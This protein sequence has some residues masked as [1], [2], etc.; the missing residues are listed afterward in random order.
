MKTKLLSITLL[1]IFITSDLFAQKQDRVIYK[2]DRIEKIKDFV[3][4]LNSSE[5]CQIYDSLPEY[6]KTYVEYQRLLEADPG[7][8]TV[9]HEKAEE[10]FR[11]VS[12]YK[13]FPNYTYLNSY[14]QLVLPLANVSNNTSLSFAFDQRYLT[15]AEASENEKGEKTI[16]LTSVANTYKVADMKN[17]TLN[18]T[19]S[20]F[21]LYVVAGKIQGYHYQ[22]E[23]ISKNS[24][25]LGWGKSEKRVLIKD[26]VESCGVIK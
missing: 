7:F 21:K 23:Q 22:T 26:S 3:A 10:L 4:S 1:S 25:F 8:Q 24:G 20:T 17:I 12:S 13:F 5:S 18:D 6:R 15:T 9:D 19:V 14:Q 11:V 16:L 2:L